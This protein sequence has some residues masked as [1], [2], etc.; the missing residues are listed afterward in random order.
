MRLPLP[1]YQQYGSSSS[2]RDC[3]LQ[4]M[5]SPSALKIDRRDVPFQG[6]GTEDVSVALGHALLRY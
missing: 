5:P 6:S 2:G 4:I 1:F 3:G